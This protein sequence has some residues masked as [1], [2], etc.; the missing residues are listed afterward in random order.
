MQK[1]GTSLF[2][3]PVTST[4]QLLLLRG[5]M[6]DKILEFGTVFDWISPL[7]AEVQDI[8]N[9]PS[10]TFFIP[11]NCNWSGGEIASLLR[12]HGVRTWGHMTVNRT[13]MITVRQ[14]Q[15]R[16]AQYLLEREG[17]P[18]QY[19]VLDE[20]TSRTF[21]SAQKDDQAGPLETIT[22]WFDELAGLLDQ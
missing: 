18:I 15:A 11:E 12:S 8:V 2:K 17:I 14:A 19:G 21:R 1:A 7:I 9:G 10:H 5:H 16:W 13:R 3:V 4:A 6:L 20:S 22:H